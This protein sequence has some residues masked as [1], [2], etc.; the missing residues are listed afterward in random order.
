MTA[1]TGRCRHR[2]LP[3]WKWGSRPLAT[4]LIAVVFFFFMAIGMPVSVTM[5]AVGVVSIVTVVHVPLEIVPQ[6]FI[7]HL[8]SFELLAVPFFILAGEI[9][10]TG[11]LTTRIFNLAL[12]LVGRIAGGLAQVNIV[13]SLIFAGISGAAVADAAGLGRVEHK[14]M[15]G[16]GYKS[17]FAAAVTLASCLIGPLIPPSI[18]MVVYAVQAQV[19]VGR[20]LLAGVIP[21]LLMAVLLM[22][23]VYWLAKTGRAHCPTVE[24][25]RGRAALKILLQGLPAV[26]APFIIVLGLVGGVFTATETGIAASIYTFLIATM[27]YR[28][29]AWSDFF[30]IIERTVIASAL[31]M[32]LIGAAG[33][34]SWVITWDQGVYALAQWFADVP[35]AQALKL[36]ALVAFLL[37]IGLAIEGVPAMLIIVPVFLP[38][39]GNLGVD[40]IQFGVMMA[41][42]MGIGLLTPPV[43]LALFVVA[44]FTHLSVE[45]LTRAVVPFMIPLIA[46]LVLVTFVPALSTW[47]PYAVFP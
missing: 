16:A 29:L 21:G 4:I 46:V 17:D 20:M 36:L 24:M 37:I 45:Q 22:A 43:G 33:P 31:V 28:E 42:A 27:F 23:F 18:A 41:A 38:V 25:P 35:I 14:A 9:M 11:G 34:M 39:I 30:R 2:L 40:P 12:L 7:S 26:V 5:L 6:N 47:L 8:S 1:T 15:T 19:S 13:A 10:N 3:S 44:G 32:F